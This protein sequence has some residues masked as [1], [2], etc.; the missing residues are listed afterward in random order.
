M[1]RTCGSVSA[2]PSRASSTSGSALPGGDPRGRGH[3]ILHVAAAAAQRVGVM[4]GLAFRHL[5]LERGGQFGAARRVVDRDDCLQVGAPRV[6]PSAVQHRR[7]GQRRRRGIVDHAARTAAVHAMPAPAGG[8][9]S[10]TCAA[11]SSMSCC[12]NASASSVHNSP[13]L[14]VAPG[15]LRA[16]RVDDHRDRGLGLG[17]GGDLGE[18]LNPVEEFLGQVDPHHRPQLAALQRHQ[19]Q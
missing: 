3:R 8:D 4:R 7:D 2:Q 14:L 9:R 18:V 1:S 5:P 19:D 16:V 12:A 13:V 11:H 6:E 17:G 15:T 10:T